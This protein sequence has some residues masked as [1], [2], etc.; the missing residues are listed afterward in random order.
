MSAPERL[1][2]EQVQ[3]AI[4]TRISGW[5]VENGAIT[6][7]Y[8]TGAW[9]R[10]MM[11]ANAIAYVAERVN[12]H[13]DLLLSYPRLKVMLT[14]HDAGGITDKDVALAEEI[15]RVAAWQPQGQ[16]LGAESWIG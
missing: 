3:G 12:H 6:R 14:T 1:S 13:P 9:T 4:R 5:T 8:Q 15:E 11:I 7:T 2:D 16:A 10:T